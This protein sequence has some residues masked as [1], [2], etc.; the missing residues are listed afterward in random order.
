MA[1]PKQQRCPTCD[2]D[3]TKPN[4]VSQRGYRTGHYDKDEVF[5]PD[6][7]EFIDEDCPDVCV[8]CVEDI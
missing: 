8:K 4:T 1:K 2:A 5:V 7:D 3:L 6:N